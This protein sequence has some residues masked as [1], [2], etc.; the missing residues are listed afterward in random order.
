[1]RVGTDFI[2]WQGIET[3]EKLQ[4]E[5]EIE[6]NWSCVQQAR[7]VSD[8]MLSRIGVIAEGSFT[9]EPGPWRRWTSAFLNQDGL[10]HPFLL[11]RHGGVTLD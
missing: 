3:R 5:T 11:R 10:H 1:M 8:P 6:L 2:T 9:D 4:R 7:P